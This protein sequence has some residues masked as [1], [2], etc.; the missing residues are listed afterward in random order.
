[1]ESSSIS[2]VTAFVAGVVSFLSPCVLPVVPGYVSYIAGQDVADKTAAIAVRDR[3]ATL[4]LSMFFVLGFSAVFVALGASATA[5]GSF[6]LRYRYEGNLLGGTIVIVFG[7][8]M[9]GAFRRMTWIQRDFRLQLNVPGGAPASAFLLGVA[10]GF[11]WTPCI[12]PILGAIL[13]VSA[14]QSSQGGMVLLTAYA[15]GLGVPF[16]LA[17]VFMGTMIERIKA[18]RR[19]GRRLQIAAGIVMVLFGLAMITG[20]LAA[21]SYW[22][23][24]TFPPLGRIG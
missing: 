13:T 17:A 19:V 6:F 10:F 11:G 21:F 18:L 1:M 8:V 16:L 24:E 12:G 4:M 20:K 2:F 14:V 5:L 7:L 3:L 15:L 9:L 22:L 23:L